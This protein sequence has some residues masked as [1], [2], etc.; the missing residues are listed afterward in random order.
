MK[1]EL[2][3]L[4]RKGADSIRLVHNCIHWRTLVHKFLRG[5]CRFCRPAYSVHYTMLSCRDTKRRVL[6]LKRTQ[7]VL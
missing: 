3:D 1:K 6:M 2:K 7:K 5:I 4:G